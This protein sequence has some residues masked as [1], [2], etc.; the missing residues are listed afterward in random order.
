VKCVITAGPT[1]EKLDGVRRLTNFSTGRLGTNLGNFL[2]ERGHSVTLLIGEQAT[3]HGERKAQH[4]ATFTTTAD[5]REH[6]QSLGNQPVDAV[7]HAAA[8]S[9][10]TF[11]MIWHRS[12]KGDL[13]EIRSG[14]LSTRDGTL[15]AELIPTPK[16]ISE[17]RQWFPQARLVGWKFEVEGGPEGVLR[18]AG[19]QIAE[20]RTDACVA[21]G[22]AYGE[23]F[24]LV[25]PGRETAHCANPD[26]LFEAL[27]ILLRAPSDDRRGS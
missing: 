14:K 5:L 23:G 2:R 12:A 8:V 11:G 24:A 27:E 4:V 22:P 9:D 10:F 20:C 25:R 26:A 21:N 19:K 16:I 15:L 7:F 1:Y 13:T 17:L 3:W 18:L 6:L